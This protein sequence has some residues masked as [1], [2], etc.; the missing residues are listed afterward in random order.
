MH[1]DTRRTDIHR[2]LDDGARLHL[3][4]FRIGISQTAAAVPQHGID[5]AQLLDLGRDLL[6][7]YAHLLGQLALLL[8]EMGH[9]LVQ[10]GIKQAHRHGVSFHHLEEALE[11]AALDGQQ[12]RQRHAAARLVVG[13]DHLAHGLDAVALE[14]HVLRAAQADALRT[15]R[16]RLLGILRRIGVGAHFQH[17]IFTGQLHQ[18]AEVAAQVGVARGDLAEV[19]LAGRT[20]ERN[21]V[22]L[23][24]RIAVDLDRACLVVDLQLAGT[25]HAALAHT[26]RN[27]RRVR[28]H[29]AACGEDARSVEHP[30][31]IF[32]RSLDTH[33][34]RLLT[35]LGQHLFGIVGEEDHRPRRGARRCGQTLDD[36]LGVLDRRLVEDGVQ[37]LVQLGRLATQHGGFLVD[38]PLAQHVHGDFDHRSARALAVAALQHPQLAV[39]NGEL[40]VLHVGEVLLQMM[41]NLV[42]LL[43]DGRHH[44]LQRR[45]FRTT[46][47][48]RNILRLGPTLRPLDGDLLRRAD[49]RH[50]VFALRIDEV[51]AVED[52]L[53]RGGIARE[54]YARRRIFAHVAED[55]RLYRHGRTPL[56]RDVVELAVE[57]GT[58][59]H[60]RTENGAHGTPQLIPRIGGEI[61]A[62]LLLDGGLERSD[63]FFQIVGRQFGI[64]LHAA[65]GLLLLDEHLERIVIL[66][67]LRLHTQHH[68]AVHLYEAAVGIPCKTRIARALGHSL[69]GHV[70]HAEVQNRIHHTRHRRAGAR[71]H[72]DQQRHGLV[73]EAHVRELLDVFHRTL[74]FGAQQLDDLILSVSVILRTYLRRD[75]KARGNG[76]AD[77]IHLGQIGTLTAQQLAHL[78]ISFGGLVAEG[79]NT[80][81]ICHNS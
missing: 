44:L 30:L 31:Q 6:E 20:V 25:R 51:L 24:D 2:S 35:R 1:G 26:A 47:L 27:D 48:L 10:R 45:I 33:Q 74:H 69:D 64:L 5:L 81:Y 21:P 57:N 75:R 41:L 11:V 78:A 59:V 76:N 68:V 80:F 67:R 54:G 46:L 38:Q 4:N 8:L 79:I 61:L 23:L 60:P 50:H 34:H 3:R 18:L 39:L 53:A 70:V 22:A 36:H 63:Q 19:D 14:E 9:E 62:R 16:E 28:R 58:L 32:G 17:R 29:T 37:Q 40:D 71:T 55:H 77:E 66:L 65:F 73:T 52:V 42:E 49:T 7:G 15:E 43:V 12:L 72:R 56:G 13:Q